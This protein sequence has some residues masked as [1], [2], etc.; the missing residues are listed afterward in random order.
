VKLLL[1]FVIVVAVIGGRTPMLAAAHGVRGSSAVV[2]TGRSPAP[3]ARS[4]PTVVHKGFPSARK[5]V[6]PKPVDPWRFWPE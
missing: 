1:T 4:A 6:S 2:V 3:F 5:S